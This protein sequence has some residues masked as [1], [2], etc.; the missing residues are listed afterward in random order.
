MNIEKI[1]KSLLHSEYREAMEIATECKSSGV[2][3]S[4]TVATA[5][6][7]GLVAGRKKQQVNLIKAHRRNAELRELLEINGICSQIQCQAEI[8]L[9]EQL[10]KCAIIR[11]FLDR[12]EEAMRSQLNNSPTSG[13]EMEDAENE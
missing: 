9:E 10:Q 13:D 11:K 4:E 7:A 5:Y 1:R 6:K 12:A 2:S 8:P 3:I